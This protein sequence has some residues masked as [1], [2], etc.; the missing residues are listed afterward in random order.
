MPDKKRGRPNKTFI[1]NRS[2]RVS[3]RMSAVE[4]DRMKIAA[5][6]AGMSLSDFIR[7]RFPEFM[8]DKK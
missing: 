2:K 1:Y 8:F 4:R 7:S 3:V 5:K 6:E